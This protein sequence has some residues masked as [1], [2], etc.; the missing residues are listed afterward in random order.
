MK[1]LSII[2]QARNNDLPRNVQKLFIE[3]NEVHNYKQ[4][5]YQKEILMKNTVEPRQDP[6]L[7][8]SKEENLGII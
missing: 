3:T 7:S 2:H 1:T 6:W 8:V 4:G 5:L